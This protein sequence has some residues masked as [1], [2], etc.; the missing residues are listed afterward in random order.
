MVVRFAPFPIKPGFDRPVASALVRFGAP[1]ALSALISQAVLN[2]DYIL[3]GR[4]LGSIELGVYLLAFNLSSWPASL[5]ST[6]IAR[7]AFAGFSRLVED[8]ERLVSAFPRSIGVAVSVVVPLVV[9]LA[10]LGPEVITFVYGERWLEAATPLR[11]LVVLGGL[12]VLIDLFVDLSIADGRPKVALTVR[13]IWLAL[14]VP[15]I[16]L[17][18]A[19]DGL[20]GVG[21]AHAAVAGLV[22]VPLLLRDARRSGIT[23][24]SLAEHCSR[25]LLAGVVAAVVML[26][27]RPLVPGELASLVLVGAAGSVAYLAAFIP[28]NPLVG[29]VISQVRPATA[30]AVS[31]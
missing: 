9:L 2:V 11:F 3:V 17:G 21:I 24:A 22:I 6:A 23:V 8:R 13:S 28:R 26:I 15:G 4:E 7:V 14:L 19:V 25:P 20:R 5:V 30:P 18:A 12:R 27:V 1:L 16:A 29:W 10:I 31:T